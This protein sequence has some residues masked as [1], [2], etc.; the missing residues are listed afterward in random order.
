[1]VP[2]KMMFY[3]PASEEKKSQWAQHETNKHE[4]VSK[5]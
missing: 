2:R 3:V 4:A 5:M 1:M